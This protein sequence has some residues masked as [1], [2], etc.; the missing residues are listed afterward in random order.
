MRSSV[1]CTQ[2]HQ[3]FQ[4]TKTFSELTSRLQPTPFSYANAGIIMTFSTRIVLALGLIATAAA[5]PICVGSRC[6][7]ACGSDTAKYPNG[8]FECTS[9]PSHP[10][11]V[12][13][14]CQ[15]IAM[16]AV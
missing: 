8:N 10:L 13:T 16:C 3:H 4:H 14:H 1:Q 7:E 2:R 9:L 11:V 5:T 15:I 6:Q 12:H